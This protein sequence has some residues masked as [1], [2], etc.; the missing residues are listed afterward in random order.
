[1]FIFKI[2]S[3]PLCYDCRV[4]RLVASF[5]DGL[6]RQGL[7]VWVVRRSADLDDWNL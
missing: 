6:R 1:M 2:S 5:G 4:A 3:I 7:L